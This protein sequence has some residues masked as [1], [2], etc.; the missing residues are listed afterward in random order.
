MNLVPT[1]PL[2]SQQLTNHQCSDRFPTAF[3]SSFHSFKDCSQAPF[4]YKEAVCMMQTAS[5]FSLNTLV[6]STTRILEKG[7]LKVLIL[8]CKYFFSSPLSAHF[9]DIQTKK[10]RTQ[11]SLSSLFTYSISFW[12]CFSLILERV[13]QS[14]LI[15]SLIANVY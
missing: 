13:N 8:D 1:M 3:Y 6:T 7:T 12:S 9:K 10:E 15:G 2:V 11:L 4:S 5:L 14:N